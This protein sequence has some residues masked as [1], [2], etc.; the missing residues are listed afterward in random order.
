MGR[1][2]SGCPRCASENSKIAQWTSHKARAIAPGARAFPMTWPGAQG[3]N[4]H[5]E[6]R[7]I[8]IC[9]LLGLRYELVSVP[10]FTP[11]RTTR[12]SLRLTRP[13]RSLNLPSQSGPGARGSGQSLSSQCLS[14]PPMRRAVHRCRRSACR[15]RRCRASRTP[16][17]PCEI[18]GNPKA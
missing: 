11:T 6:P 2:A 12:R 18:A 17:R 3:A 1:G 15:H 14:Q 4:P 8:P 16:G 7:Y 10:P 9:G 13:P 5:E